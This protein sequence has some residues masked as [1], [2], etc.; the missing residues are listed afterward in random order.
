MRVGLS[1]KFELAAAEHL[2]FERGEL[3][4]DL[5]ADDRFPIFEYFFELLHRLFTIL[6]IG[7]CRSNGSCTVYRFECGGSTQHVFVLEMRG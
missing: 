1:A 7:K 6:S 4:V 5:Q 3:G 2:G